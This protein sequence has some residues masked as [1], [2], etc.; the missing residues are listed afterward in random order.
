MSKKTDKHS[1]DTS[2]QDRVSVIEI[3]GILFG[4]DIVKSKEIFPLTEVTPIP[5]TKEFVRGV[6]NL[7]GD[8]YPLI[9]ISTILGLQ[10]VK[11]NKDNM[12]I[13]LEGNGVTMGILAN[14]VHDV[15]PLQT[16]LVKPS[17]GVAAKGMEEF[18]SGMI[19]EK[20]S[21]IF[22]LDI[23]RLFSSPVIN[24]YY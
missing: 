11:N 5:N 3:N 14:R 9:D 13:L 1:E 6:F 24:R 20:G 10:P 17:K 22:L 2:L 15:R 18:V 8:I 19:S 12:I 4:I 7:R 21:D 16:S 23:D